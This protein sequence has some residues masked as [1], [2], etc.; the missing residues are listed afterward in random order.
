MFKDGLLSP[1][2]PSLMKDGAYFF[3]VPCWVKVDW[4]QVLYC[5]LDSLKLLFS[6]KYL[7]LSTVV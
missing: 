3:D 6:T 2:F 5:G 4:M 1:V 7:Y